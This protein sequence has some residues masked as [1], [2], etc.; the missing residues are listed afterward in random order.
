MTKNKK[1]KVIKISSLQHNVSKIIII[2]YFQNK[3]FDWQMQTLP[4]KRPNKKNKPDLK[5]GQKQ[6]VQ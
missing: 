2:K 4:D 1:N 3:G 5:K 6:T